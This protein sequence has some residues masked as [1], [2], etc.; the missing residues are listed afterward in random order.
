MCRSRRCRRALPRCL[1]SASGS[2]ASFPKR[3][4]SL[5]WAAAG[6][7]DSA[8]GVR[9]VGDIKLMARSVEGIELK[10]LQR[11][12]RRGQESSVGSGVVA[13]VGVTERRQGR[14]RRRRDPDLDWALQC[15]RSRA[16]GRRGA[17]RQRRRRPAG[18]WRRPAGPTARRLT[19]RLPPSR[20]R[21]AR[22][23]SER[24][25]SLRSFPRKRTVC[26]SFAE[27]RM[28]NKS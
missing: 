10:D 5:P 24:R 4:R 21:S 28:I 16:Q 22:K 27:T 14:H 17:G 7:A 26:P 19:L 20:R 2:S 11:P 12:R 6:K 15:R 25:F 18:L 8:D 1:T 3:R 13:I 9:A 23:R